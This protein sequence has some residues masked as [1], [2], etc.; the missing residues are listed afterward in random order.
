MEKKYGLNIVFYMK[1][2]VQLKLNEEDS[3]E[4]KIDKYNFKLTKL[5]KSNTYSMMIN[6]INNKEHAKSMMDKFK[7]ALL[8]F[9]LENNS[10]A[11]EINEE[12]SYVDIPDEPRYIE[13]FGLVSGSFNLN[14]TV[15]FPLIPN[16]FQ[17]SSF[18]IPLINSINVENLIEPI[19]K[20]DKIDVDR[21]INDEKL[22]L[23]LEIYSKLSQNPSKA[24]F[25]YLITILE[26]LKPK[27]SISNESK[28]HL[29]GIKEYIKKIRDESCEKNSEEYNTINRYLSS[30][31]FWDEQSIS[32]SLKLYIDE[33]SEQFSDYK[34]LDTELKDAYVI[35][36]KLIHG[37]II[38][39]E[40]E[41]SEKYKFLKSF[42]K[43]LLL[44]DINKYINE[45]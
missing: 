8:L 16:L 6:P 28:K 25:L 31:K 9:V 34:N 22:L 12:I 13:G 10:A 2:Y 45:K 18:Q 24:Q 44:N 30:M 42:V 37:G 39:N 33:N 23:A 17:I 3:Y 4:F 7:I 41:F 32:K 26:I 1:T 20:T 14:R 11:I 19:K 36:S 21:I 43:E 35:R 38:I 27:Y 15:M 40:K 29:K 5:K